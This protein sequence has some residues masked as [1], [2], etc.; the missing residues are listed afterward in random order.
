[1]VYSSNCTKFTEGRSRVLHVYPHE[2]YRS[3]T[4]LGAVRVNRT[5]FHIDHVKMKNVSCEYYRLNMVVKSE[6]D[7]KRG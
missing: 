4:P 2:R 1:M 5:I 3:V 6:F 7:T